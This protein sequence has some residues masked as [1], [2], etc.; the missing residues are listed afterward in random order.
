MCLLEDNPVAAYL[1]EAKVIQMGLEEGGL[2][3][4]LMTKSIGCY[5]PTL[6]F[7]NVY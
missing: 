4:I 5:K 1:Q 6:V 3:S 7:V 2:T